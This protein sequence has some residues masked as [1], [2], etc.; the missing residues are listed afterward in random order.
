M[1]SQPQETLKSA[2]IY[3]IKDSGCP[4]PNLDTKTGI[5]ATETA[6]QGNLTMT[7]CLTPLGKLLHNPKS[8]IHSDTQKR[9]IN[10]KENFISQKN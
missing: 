10:S 4:Y 9:L 8:T 6:S 3:S 7:L 2:I 1:R 5:K